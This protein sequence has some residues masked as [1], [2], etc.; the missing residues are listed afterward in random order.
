M[1]KH[2]CGLQSSYTKRE[3][4]NKKI[5]QTIV[6]QTQNTE[7]KVGRKILSVFEVIDFFFA[8]FRKQSNCFNNKTMVPSLKF[9]KACLGGIYSYLLME[10]ES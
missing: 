9:P 8:L 10:E 5:P 2:F 6:F 3:V 1:F 7:K 4:T